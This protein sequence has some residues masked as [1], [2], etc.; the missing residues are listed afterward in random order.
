MD[1]EQQC[2]KEVVFVEPM[3]FFCWSMR[4][5]GAPYAPWQRSM[6]QARAKVDISEAD[7]ETDIVYE[8]LCPG[9]YTCLYIYGWID[10]DEL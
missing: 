10:R 3:D 9:I 5:V 8:R 4:P 2:P 1:G 7:S 6:V